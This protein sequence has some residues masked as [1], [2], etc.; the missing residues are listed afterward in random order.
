[1]GFRSLF[2][3][4]TLAS[5]RRIPGRRPAP[6]RLSVEALETRALPSLTFQFGGAYST[7]G[8]ST[9]TVAAGDFN[10]DG[11]TD[12]ATVNAGNSTVAVLLGKPDGS[13][14]DPVTYSA[15]TGI[16]AVAAGDF[17]G[18]GKL[19]LAA[20]DQAANAVSVLPGNGDGTFG[21]PLSYAAGPAPNALAVADFNA[22]GR[23][24]LAVVN[25]LNNTVSVLLGDGMGGFQAPTTYGVGTSPVAV[26]VGDFN[27]DGKPDLVTANTGSN[28]VSVLL[29]TGGGFSAATDYT[30]GNSPLTLAVGDLNGDGH[31]DLATVSASS[32]VS[33]LLGTGT[34]TF[35]P[36]TSYAT[37]YPNYSVAIADLNRDGKADLAL[38]FANLTV[39]EVSYDTGLCECVGGDGFNLYSDSYPSVDCYPIYATYYSSEFDAGVTFLEGRGN[40]AFGPETDVT[41]YSYSTDSYFGVPADE[42]ETVP[43]LAVSDIDRNG[44][45]DLAAVNSGGFVAV[46]INTQPQAELQMSISPAST[47]AGVARS[48]TVSAFDLAGN[49]DPTYT[50]TVHFTSSDA[51]AGLPT[52]YTFTAADHGVHTFSV[53]LD[54]AGTQSVTAFDGVSFASAT[55]T[56]Q[57]T[58]AAASTFT[59]AGPATPVSSGQAFNVTLEAFDAFGNQ[60][61][62]YTG[63]VHLS[64]SDTGATLPA[65]Y[66]FTAADQGMH[67][68]S[69]TLRADGSQTLT[70]TDT[71]A[72]AITAQMVVGVA[73]VAGLSGPAAGA[74]S[75]D[76]TFTL[77]ASGGASASTI[78]TYQIDWNGDGGIDQTVSGVSGTTVT[79]TFYFAGYTNVVMTASLGGLTSTP[80]SAGVNILPLS[81]FVEPD[82][83]DPTRQ[84][85]IVEGSGTSV[86]A[87]GAGNGVTISYNGVALGTVTPSGSLPFAHLVVYGNVIRL[88]GGLAVPAVL[89]GGAGDDTLDAQG[90]IA[91]NV[92]VGGSGNDTLL[93]GSGNDILIG[94]L[95][96]DTLKGNGGDDILIGGTTRYDNDFVALFSLLREW[97][98]SDESYSTRVSH[99]QGGSGGINGSSVLTPATVFDDGVTDTLYGNA[100]LD[101]FFA[102]VPGNSW[103]K[104]RVQDRGST[105]V[106]TSL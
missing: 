88:T 96:N 24:D 105:E 76:L 71:H 60:A 94:G 48:V 82:V 85:L 100:G 62:G 43:A 49:P 84:A 80:V 69:V 39:T 4:V 5:R 18:D 77:T 103:Q 95:G 22:D 21:A 16:V 57:V 47:T 59:L 13:F 30:T 27:G 34:S 11:V 41:T 66:T 104:D 83:A 54:T 26:A 75:Q 106:L 91:A 15:G 87:P 7:G 98:R 40:G 74:I 52:D 14:A 45:P 86:L 56:A 78:F 101:W 61:T 89:F 38:G 102:R 42:F 92:L 32:G 17:N 93:G 51:Q 20:A 36:P 67:T 2:D 6:R 50:G 31:A 29:G 1:M 79:H 90:S 23:A 44:S 65:D 9:A 3:F 68:F 35:G 63:T 58:P 33:V 10:H 25:G 55:V 19:D 46:L 37:S 8:G 53:T 73:P 70:A 99:L 28:S 64:S 72:P 97:S 12:L 81:V